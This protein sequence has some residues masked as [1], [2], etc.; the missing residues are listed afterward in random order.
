MS[1]HPSWS[2]RP[3]G[4]F[5]WASAFLSPAPV[6]RPTRGDT[7]ADVLAGPFCAQPAPSV[8][9]ALATT[10]TG[11]TSSEARARRLRGGALAPHHHRTELVLLLRQFSNPITLILIFATLVSAVLGETTDAAIIL[12]IILLSGLLSFWHEYA[13]SRAVEDLLAAVHV[14]VEVWRDGKRTFVP[15]TEAVAGDVVVLDTGDLI[16]GDSLLLA[17]QDLLVDEAPLTGESFPVEKSPG[18]LPSDTAL[19]GRSNCLFLGTHVV[20][21]SATAV[22]VHTGS[23]TELGHIAGELERRPAVTRF[24]RGLTDFGRLLLSVMVVLVLLIFAANLLL[25]RPLIESFL[26]SVAI[27]VG[28]TPQMLPAIVSVSLSL[29]ARR[30]VRVKVIVKRLSAIE[31]FGSMNVLCTDKT[32]TLTQGAVRLGS[33]L[34]IDGHPSARVLETAY[35]NAFH[36]TGFANPIDAAVLAHGHVPTAGTRRFD[37]L[38]YDFQRQR[39]SVLIEAHDETLLVTKGAVERVLGICDHAQRPDGS[40]VPLDAV[41]EETYKQFAALSAQGYR[42]LGVAAKSFPERIQLGPTDEAGS[43]FLGFLTFLDPPKPGIART[44][45]SCR[46]WASRCAW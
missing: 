15:S 20:R 17:T 25:A 39:L 28:L 21:G 45:A 46:R 6:P 24:E 42:V 12:A 22:V 19:T 31:D 5:E 29:G 44:C 9:R 7:A 4:N 16:P 3:V 36:H 11:L 2:R 43:T 40:I 38:P 33:A 18:V 8:R 34:G 27:A 10:P 14:T 30:M 23:T 32:G 37:E 1:A 13:A 26:F 41:A 35:L